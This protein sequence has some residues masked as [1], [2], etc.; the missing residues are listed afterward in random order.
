[1]HKP[2]KPRYIATWEVQVVLNYLGSLIPLSILRVSV[3]CLERYNCIHA[4]AEGFIKNNGQSP[5]L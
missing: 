5:K 1:M 3:C 2:S 4:K